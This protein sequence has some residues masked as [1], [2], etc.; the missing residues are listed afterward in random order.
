MTHYFHGE[1]RV[2][3][4]RSETSKFLFQ[5]MCS[6]AMIFQ[7]YLKNS[8]KQG[9]SIAEVPIQES[10]SFHYNT[11]LS[12]IASR[13]QCNKRMEERDAIV[14]SQVLYVCMCALYFTIAQK[15]NL[16]CSFFILWV[17]GSYMIDTLYPPAKTGFIQS[18]KHQRSYSKLSEYW[19]DQE[20]FIISTD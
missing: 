4:E 16:V 14:N 9:F 15:V 1:I 12:E 10:F 19:L 17:I 3:W 18:A 20:W 7:W 5:I 13:L 8:L 6:L 11:C 2:S